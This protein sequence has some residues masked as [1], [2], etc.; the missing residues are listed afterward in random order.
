[1]D[2]KTLTRAIDEA[3]VRGEAGEGK[4]YNVKEERGFTA[5]DIEEG[6]VGTQQIIE[7]IEKSMVLG[8]E[9]SRKVIPSTYNEETEVTGMDE[10]LAWTASTKQ[11]TMEDIQVDG[12]GSMPPGVGVQVQDSQNLEG[13][14][15]AMPDRSG[16]PDT[17]D[18][19]NEEGYLIDMVRVKREM[20]RFMGASMAE[21]MRG[22]EKRF[23]LG[24]WRR[25]ID[26]GLRAWAENTAREY[27]REKEEQ[28]ETDLKLFIRARLQIME[29]SLRHTIMNRLA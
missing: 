6:R 21:A 15:P 24:R 16:T 12:Y 2:G 4:D 14:R 20:V 23:G 13:V 8:R 29:E 11:P 18:S 10:G 19:Q 3:M 5:K 1:M 26:E 17:D 22:L 9:E 28:R 7:F 27:W 25:E